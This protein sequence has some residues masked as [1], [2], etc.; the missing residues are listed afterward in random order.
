MKNY[1]IFC[2]KEQNH[3]LFYFNNNSNKLK[4]CIINLIKGI[5]I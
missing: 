1:F 5:K 3:L 2:L 4:N